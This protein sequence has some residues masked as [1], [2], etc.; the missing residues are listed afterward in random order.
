[1]IAIKRAYDPAEKSDGTRFLIDHLWPRGVKKEA[2][3]IQSWIKAVSPSDQLRKWFGHEPSKWKEFQ[4]RYF[5][6]L[7]DKPEAWKPLLAA[8]QTGKVTLIYSAKN[9]EHNNA[10]ALKT[11]LEKKLA[12][13]PRKPRT[14]LVPA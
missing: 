7:K 11:F 5:A 2:L 12:T 3:H 10:I 4:H 9:T 14:K 13:K 6:E 1:M 8:A